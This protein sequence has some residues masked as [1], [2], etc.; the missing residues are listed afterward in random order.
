MKVIDLLNE[1]YDKDFIATIKGIT[2]PTKIDLDA[3]DDENIRS[4][5]AKDGWV[6]NRLTGNQLK[7]IGNALSFMDID[8]NKT[9]FWKSDEKNIKEVTRTYDNT[10]ESYYRK[11]NLYVHHKNVPAIIIVTN[12][13]EIYVLGKN[14]KNSFRCLKIEEASLNFVKNVKTA[15]MG[16]K[17]FQVIKMSPEAIGRL[18]T[19]IKY[20][21]QLSDERPDDMFDFE[22]RINKTADKYNDRKNRY[23]NLRPGSKQELKKLIM[24]MISQ[25]GFECNLNKIDVSLITD[26]SD[27]FAGTKFNGDISKWDVSN[28][29]NMSGMFADSKFN[30]RIAKW[31]VSNVCDMSGMFEGSVFNKDISKWNV[32]RLTDATDMFRDSLFRGNISSWKTKSLKHI[33]YMFAGSAFKGDLESWND[34]HIR[35]GV[36]TFVNSPLEGKEPRWY[37]RNRIKK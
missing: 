3:Y 7:N 2:D 29:K 11:L 15:R 6:E 34:S 19:E 12:D 22:N 16:S 26:M 18:L 8:V 27:L 14:G 31:D 4:L 25:F 36:G 30:G 17:G 37:F 24:D 21:W 23:K 9:H 33:D 13:D 5:S 1:Y 28:V 32:E 10:Y 20:M 35:T